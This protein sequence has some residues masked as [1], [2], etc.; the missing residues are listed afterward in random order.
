MHSIKD[1]RPNS[2]RDKKQQF[3][4]NYCKNQWEL[5][6][7]I[8]NGRKLEA[9]AQSAKRIQADK[10]SKEQPTNRLKKHGRYKRKANQENMKSARNL[11]KPKCI[12]C[13]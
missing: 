9:A 5:E 2:Y 1:K 7:L 8:F 11:T 13:S 10:T 4:S 12:N 6:A 3:P